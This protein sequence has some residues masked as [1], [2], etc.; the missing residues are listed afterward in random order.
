[1][2]VNDCISQMANSNLPFGGVGASGSGRYHGKAGFENCSNMKSILYKNPI[3][4]W[5]F[6]C[7]IPPYTPDKVKLITMLATK[8]DYTQQ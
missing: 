6:N 3:S 4:I 2:V 8:V 5:P 1:M 7:A